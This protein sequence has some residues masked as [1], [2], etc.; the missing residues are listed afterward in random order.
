MESGKEAQP[1]QPISK[2][3]VIIDEEN[4]YEEKN[5]EPSTRSTRLLVVHR[6]RWHDRAASPQLQ[7]VDKRPY[8]EIVSLS[9]RD[10]LRPLL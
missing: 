9:G 8:K 1:Y 7:A 6:P 5:H 3:S 4:R 10:E 2:T